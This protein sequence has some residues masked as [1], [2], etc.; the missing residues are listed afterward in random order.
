ME[1][2]E[3]RAA[4]TRGSDLGRHVFGAAAL[5][6]GLITLVWH[7]ATHGPLFVYAAAVAQ[8]LGGAAIQSPRTART[9]AAVL[10]AAYLVFA[11]LCVPQIISK[12]Q[13][14][15]SWGN[16]FE[17]FSL[18]TGAAIAY[19]RSSPRWSPETVARLGR[20]LLGLCVT[21]FAL[22]QAFYLD[23]T[24]QLVPRW[25]PP[26]PMFWAVATTVFFGL[27]ALAL[28]TNRMALPAAR[29][30]TAMILVFGFV[31]WIPLL[32]ANPHS[33]SSWSETAETFAI[34]GAIWILADLLRTMRL[35]D[36][37]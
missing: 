34:A 3:K 10:A 23:A 17:P 22:E 35:D 19:A 21:S 24:A 36:L 12:P 2:S 26:S 1:G 18:A 5:A 32:F 8:I 13:I 20:I 37:R 11:A 6:S 30:L 15:N 27:G 28:L 31:V 25:F 4:F 14:Y 16:F 7:N 29:L 33:H 9:G